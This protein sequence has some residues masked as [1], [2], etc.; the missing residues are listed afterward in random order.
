MEEGCAAPEQDIMHPRVLMEVVE[1]VSEMLTDI[2]KSSLELGQVLE[3]WR[4]ENV[5]P[6]FKKGSR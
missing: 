5:T 2:L 3:D 6:L 4:G 1:Q